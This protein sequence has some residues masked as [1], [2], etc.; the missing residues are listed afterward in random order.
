[1]SRYKLFP[2]LGLYSVFSAASVAKAQTYFNETFS[3]YTPGNLV[4]QNGWVQLGAATV[5]P[6]QVSGGG[7]RVP[8]TT[9][10]SQDA[11]RNLTGSAVGVTGASQ[12]IAFR[13]TVNAAAV[14]TAASPSY[15]AALTTDPNGGG[16]ANYRFTAREDPVDPSRFVF[17]ARVTGQGTSP[18]VF[19]GASFAEGSEQI[20]ILETVAGGT[21]VNVYAN[22]T[23]GSQGSQTLYLTQTGGTPP[24]SIGSVNISQFQSASAPINDTTF[25]QVAAAGT[26]A[27]A[28]AAIVPVPEPAS[29]LGFAAL[30]GAAA[31]RRG[32][33]RGRK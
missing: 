18:Y 11:Y 24:V 33:V 30:V 14:S 7:V 20:V 3:T 16:F 19:G 15:F 22:P 28:Y 23:S 4:G 5:N 12:Y 26:F 6:L 32:V 10:D 25:Y 27:E 21:T 29:V 13:L 8:L 17:G 2:L 9:G 31:V 1:M